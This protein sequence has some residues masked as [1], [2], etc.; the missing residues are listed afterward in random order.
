M[1]QQFFGFPKT[2]LL[3]RIIFYKRNVGAGVT[4]KALY[5]CFCVHRLALFL[6]GFIGTV[7]KAEKWKSE[8][9]QRAVIALIETFF[10]K[11]HVR[12]LFSSLCLSPHWGSLCFFGFVLAIN[13]NQAGEKRMQENM[14]VRFGQTSHISVRATRMLI[15]QSQ[16]LMHGVSWLAAMSN[17]WLLFQRFFLFAVTLP[18]SLSLHFV[19]ERWIC[20]CFNGVVISTTVLHAMHLTRPL[21]TP[22]NKRKITMKMKK[23]IFTKKKACFQ[24]QIRTLGWKTKQEEKTGTETSTATCLACK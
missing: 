24:S 22:F 4:H 6:F 9:Q 5:L 12:L 19:A 1:A 10:T 21:H 18:L 14:P 15:S 11:R 20:C 2:M 7:S 13:R 23:I 17:L 3:Y 16:N 8:H